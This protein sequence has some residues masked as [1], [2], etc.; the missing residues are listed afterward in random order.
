MDLLA[1]L[2]PGSGGLFLQILAGGL[3]GVATIFVVLRRKFASL[4]RFGRKAE[5]APASTEEA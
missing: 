2:D 3:A 5:E 1:Y 4:F